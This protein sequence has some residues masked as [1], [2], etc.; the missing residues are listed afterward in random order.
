MSGF[1]LS[2]VFGTLIAV[3]FSQSRWLRLGCFPYAVILQTIPIVAI[4]PLITY[5][6]GAGFTSVM[7]ISFVVSVFPIITNTLTGK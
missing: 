1:A 3:A 5:W 2:L 4:A 6:N 7:L